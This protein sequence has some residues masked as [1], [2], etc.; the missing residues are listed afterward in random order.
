MPLNML[1]CLAADDVT[2]DALVDAI[3]LCDGHLA[4]SR[5]QGTNV[6]HVVLCEFDVRERASFRLTVFRVAVMRVVGASADEQMRRVHAPPIVAG[7]ADIHSWWD[8]AVCKLIRHSVRNQLM[9]VFLHDGAVAAARRG[10]CPSPAL[11]WRAFGKELAEPFL[12]W[13]NR[14]ASHGAGPR[15]ITLAF[16]F[17][18][19][20]VAAYTQHRVAVFIA[21]LSWATHC[22]RKC[23]TASN[24][25]TT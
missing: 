1:P 13:W 10:A 17:D 6:Q 8:R 20:G 15:A 23:I 12:Q 5:I 7:M 22:D 16:A 21:W 24:W 9:G 25:T 3:A 11:M 18:R 14:A 2:N 4:H 19:A